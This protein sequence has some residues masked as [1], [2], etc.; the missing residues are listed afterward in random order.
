[1]KEYLPRKRPSTIRTYKGQL[2]KHIK[3]FFGKF[4]RVAD[5]D[6][7]DIDKLHRRVSAAG[8]TYAANRV[9]ALCSKMF[10]L[11]IKWKMRGT[12]PCKGIERNPRPSAGGICQP[13][14]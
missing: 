10:S 3:P 11:A 13:M 4:K 2:K 8:S 12:N 7:A 1:M 9:V 5:V 6:Y 14:S